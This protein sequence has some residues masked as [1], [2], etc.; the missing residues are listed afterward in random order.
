MLHLKETEFVLLF[1]KRKHKGVSIIAGRH[2]AHLLDFVIHVSP[3]VRWFVSLTLSSQSEN[4]LSH[5]LIFPFTPKKS[6]TF[7]NF[8]SA[9]IRI[10]LI[11]S[12]PNA[13][14]LSSA[15]EKINTSCQFPVI[16]SAATT[17]VRLSIPCP[18]SPHPTPI[19]PLTNWQPSLWGFVLG[20]N[21]ETYIYSHTPTQHLI[22]C[23]DF[24]RQ[25]CRSPVVLH[26]DRPVLAC[27]S[28]WMCSGLQGSEQHSSLSAQMWTLPDMSDQAESTEN[29]PAH[30]HCTIIKSLKCAD[31]LRCMRCCLVWPI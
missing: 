30:V 12:A 17:H 22:W 13:M 16:H 6:K 8:E 9:M 1:K 3:L 19:K 25:R 5:R 15:K 24:T 29:S 26:S 20:G 7:V 21:T 10:N 31:A 28:L 14:V 2:D 4:I 23:Q 11:F 18:S 27:A